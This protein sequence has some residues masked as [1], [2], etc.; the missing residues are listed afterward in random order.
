M[1][2]LTS[3]CPYTAAKFEG[4]YM[5]SQKILILF[6]HPTFKRSR[7]NR[8]LVGPLKS[9]EQVT[10]HD[11]YEAYPNFYIDVKHEQNLL[12]SHDIIAFMH[13]FH[14][15][16]TPAIL[17]EW[18]DLVL[19]RGFAYG[20]NGRA[21]L[22]K[23]LLSIISMEGSK[24]SYQPKGHNHFNVR[25]L[26]API[27]QTAYHCGMEYLNPFLVHSASSLTDGEIM[28]HA[29]ELERRIIALI[30]NNMRVA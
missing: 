15:Y 27:E 25:Q 29:K 7:V 3:V 1:L 20:E 17:K 24:E 18:Q 30:Q 5:H 4:D 19:E 28:Q 6:A 14:W 8:L 2:Y 9:L 10:F 16:S 12:I 11:L 13:P 23:K 21:L 26:L 22:G